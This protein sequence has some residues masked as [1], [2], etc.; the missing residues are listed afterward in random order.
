VFVES[1]LYGV[2][3]FDQYGVELGKELARALLS[4]DTGSLDA[5]A[6]EL[7]ARIGVTP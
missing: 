5:P 3:A 4:G 1:V 6:K 7:A 2:N